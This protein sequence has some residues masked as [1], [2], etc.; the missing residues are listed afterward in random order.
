MKNG[1][2]YNGIFN[3]FVE[4]LERKAANWSTSKVIYRDGKRVGV[5]L[6]DV[7]TSLDTPEEILAKSGFSALVPIVCLCNVIVRFWSVDDTFSHA[8][9]AA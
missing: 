6:D 8:A 2:D 3:G 1:I 7:E 9:P 4:Y 5:S